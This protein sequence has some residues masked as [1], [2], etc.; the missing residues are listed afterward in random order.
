MIWAAGSTPV[1]KVEAGKLSLPFP[2]NSRGA[3]QTDPTLRVRAESGG[4][5]PFFARLARR[6]WPSEL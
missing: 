3:T 6:A 1:P 2:A 4:R 5:L